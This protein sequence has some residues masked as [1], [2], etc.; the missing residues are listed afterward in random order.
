VK[1]Y[2]H[3]IGDW[4]PA[5]VDLSCTEE[6]VYR[7][8]M[9]WYYSNE[10][11]LPLTMR[12]IN[13]IARVRSNADR[14]AVR[15]V[16]SR[17]FTMADDGWHQDK[18]DKTLKTFALGD[19]VR[20]AKR[21]AAA[22]RQR[23]SRL[24]RDQL[25]AACIAK[26]IHAPFNASQ[27]QLEEILA[28]AGVTQVVTRDVTRDEQRDFA[29]DRGINQKEKSVTR[30]SDAEAPPEAA[31]PAPARSVVAVL[32]PPEPNRRAAAA[33]ALKA[34]GFPMVQANTADPRFLALLQAGVTDDELR[35][36]AAEAVARDKSWG[37]MLATI[38]GRHADVAS[39]FSRPA[40]APKRD[41]RER[42]AGLTPTIAAKPGIPF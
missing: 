25:L 4:L 9:D 42:V 38:S 40:K 16:V 2:A 24:K 7:R 30:D 14:D 21:D 23:R 27:S 28:A 20:T 35:L 13:K 33:K 34:G 8:L 41:E 10:A 6:G 19:A 37:W 22:E 26:G 18:I 31:P 32:P 17:F 36:T 15:V 29:R 12:D 3:N 11:P 1:Y 39:G 5:T